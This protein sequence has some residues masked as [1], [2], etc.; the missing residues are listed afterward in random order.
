MQGTSNPRT[1][2][3]T[4]FLPKGNNPNFKRPFF[5]SLVKTYL[6]ERGLGI[7]WFA[8]QI[9]ITPSQFGKIERG[10]RQAPGTFR[11]AAA[12]LLQVPV[13]DII[14]RVEAN[15]RSDI[16]FER[17]PENESRIIR[18]LVEEKAGNGKVMER[19]VWELARAPWRRVT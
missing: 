4:R 16:I 1:P 15:K 5:I 18:V 6:I 10:E 7:K 3:P 8:D 17:D 2:V 14:L 19:V 11:A 13:D 9:N 12:L